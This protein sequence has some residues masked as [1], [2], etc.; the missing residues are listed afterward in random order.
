MPTGR[1]RR[2]AADGAR[3]EEAALLSELDELVLQGQRTRGF[4]II[5]TRRMA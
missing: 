3:P 2:G 1:R 4:S 5:R